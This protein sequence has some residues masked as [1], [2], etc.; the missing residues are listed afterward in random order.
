MSVTTSLQAGIL[1]IALSSPGK[2]DFVERM[3][4]DDIAVP[5]AFLE[6]FDKV[7]LLGKIPSNGTLATDHSLSIDGDTIGASLVGQRV[8]TQLVKAETFDRVFDLP[9]VPLQLAADPPGTNLALSTKAR[10]GTI[11]LIGIG[12]TGDSQSG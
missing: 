2:A 12:T 10:P 4:N 7:P 6:T 5:Q 11:A 3:F 9:L 1:L 8:Q